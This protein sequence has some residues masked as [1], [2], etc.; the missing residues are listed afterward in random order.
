MKFKHIRNQFTLYYVLLICLSVLL[1]EALI[2]GYSGIFFY[3][4]VE[5]QLKGELVPLAQS[6]QKSLQSQSLSATLG[7]NSDLFAKNTGYEVQVY[8]EQG[9]M[10]IYTYGQWEKNGILSP[11]VQGALSGQQQAWQGRLSDGRKM[12]TVSSPLLQN[13]Q[14]R[15][16]VRLLAPLAAVDQQVQRMAL[17]FFGI[18]LLVILVTS[19]GAYVL[20]DTVT[21]PILN[22]IRV[23]RRMS[24]GDF[25]VKAIPVY[26]DEI[27]ELAE[28]INHLASEIKK[29]DYLKN[30]MFSSVSHEL[31][32]PLT[33]IRGWAE[34]LN[35]PLYTKG[36]E[37][38]EDGLGVIVSESD[39]LQQMVEELL[40]FSRMMSI[41]LSYTF[42]TEDWVE[43]L[44]SAVNT[45][46]PKANQKH[47]ALEVVAAP[48]ELLAQL[49]AHRIQQLLI[50]LLDN[51][52]KFTPEGGTVAIWIK[53][54]TDDIYLTI[55]D[56]GC[57]IAK[58]ELPFVKER[59][60]KGSHTG[61]HLGIGLA[62]CEEIIKAHGG[63]WDIKS[64][65]GE[66]TSIEMTFPR[67]WS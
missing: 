56:T 8:D 5:I 3:N 43:L 37:E 1:F 23:T 32:T 7:A 34:T 22:L 17:Y 6:L 50:N 9:Q 2:I 13:G 20:A 44:H 27:G 41:E 58:E 52:L 39:R 4:Q 60:Y 18:G 35:D 67:A 40:D 42:E 49:D 14:I 61:S 33:A 51:A 62:I 12:M 66:G 10:L 36:S 30:R 59:F 45:M 15:G 38:L 31:R 48:R 29:R 65:L 47:I 46:K 16:V 24:A 26:A 25:S 64:A 55:K 57:G 19:V 11:D 21:T 28:G 63:I 54:E 53:S